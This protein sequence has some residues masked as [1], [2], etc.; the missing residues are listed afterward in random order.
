[1]FQSLKILV[2]NFAL[3]K[4]YLFGLKTLNT[5]FIFGRIKLCN[6]LRVGIHSMGILF[7]WKLGES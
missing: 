6:T 1:M 4:V 2:N 3:Q 7:F 5:I